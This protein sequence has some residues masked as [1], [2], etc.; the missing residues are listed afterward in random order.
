MARFVP[1]IGNR[2]FVCTQAGAI[3]LT[4]GPGDVNTEMVCPADDAHLWKIVFTMH[5]A[6]T[7]TQN[8]NL[9]VEHGEGAAGVAISGTIDVLAD[10]ADGT[11]VTADALEYSAQPATVEGTTMQILN[12]EEGAISDGAILNISFIWEL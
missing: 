6:G 2:I 11:I 9:I 12:A 1:G 7:G 3:D 4:D 8:H 5:T 10:A